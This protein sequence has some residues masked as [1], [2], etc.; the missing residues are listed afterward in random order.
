MIAW[1]HD[2]PALRQSAR[3][4]DLRAAADRERAR[5]KSYSGMLRWPL[6]EVGWLAMDFVS[7]WKAISVLSTGAFGILGLLTNSAMRTPRRS[8]LGD[9]LR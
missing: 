8:P 9:M 2:V 1:S 4:S 3:E 6:G 7:V 5:L